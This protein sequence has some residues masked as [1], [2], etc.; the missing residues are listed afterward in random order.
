MAPRTVLLFP[1]FENGEA[2]QRVRRRYDPLC[3]LI[4]PHITVAFPF[5]DGRS[6][7]DLAT[8]LCEIARRTPPFAL[9][10]RGVS[11]CSDAF[12]HWLFAPVVQG[13]GEIKDLHGALSRVLFGRD[14]LP[15]YTPHL[16][17]GKLPDAQA[18]AQAAAHTVLPGEFSCRVDTLWMEC[19]GA[20]GESIVE[21]SWPLG[22]RQ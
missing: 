11:T 6:S 2:L 5:E 16:T 3:G 8:L 4:R 17:L 7:P 19:I 14:A 20:G 22:T 10:L 12:G 18:L 15:G 13:I 9:T 1:D 21:G